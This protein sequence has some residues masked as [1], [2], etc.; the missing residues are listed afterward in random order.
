MKVILNICRYTM[1]CLP[2]KEI[3]PLAKALGFAPYTGGQA[4]NKPWYYYCISILFL[5]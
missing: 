3:N 2:V 4:V 1:V 5:G